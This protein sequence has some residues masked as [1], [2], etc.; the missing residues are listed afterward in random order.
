[1]TIRGLLLANLRYHWRSHLGVLIG[2]TLASAIITGAL[3]IGD[4]V[5]YSLRQMAL[6][7]LGEIHYALHNRGRFFRAELASAVASELK[8]PTASL[9]L[10]P[11]T[12]VGQRTDGT[13]SDV[14]VGRVQVLGVT[15]DFWKLGNASPPTMTSPTGI[16]SVALNDHLARALGVQVGDEVLLRVDKPSLLSRDAP[17]STIEDATVTLRLAVAAIVPE[18]GFGR[19][20]LEA[21]QVPPYNAF[22]PL[23]TL[24]RAVGME[25]RTNTLLVGGTSGANDANGAVSVSLQNALEALWKH[26]EFADSGLTLRPVPGKNLL[27]LRTNQVFLDTPLGEA[28]RTAVPDT[29]GVLTYFVNELRVGK[30]ATPYSTVAALQSPLLPPGMRD[31]E[32]VVNQWFADDVGAKV[33]D[34]VSLKYWLVGSMRRL[35]EH[36][37]SFRIR[38]ILPM[39][40]ATIDPALMPDIPGLSDKKDCRDWEPG[41]PVDLTKIRDKDQAY[42]DAYRG[43]PKGFITLAAGQRIWNNRFGDL[44]A[45]RYPVTGPDTRPKVEMCLRQSLSPASQGMFFQPVRENALNASSQSLDFGQLFLAFSFF[46]IVAA[47]LLT[48]LLF[49]FGVERRAGETGT[50]LALGFTP[51]RVQR[52]LLGEGAALAALASLLG[53]GLATLYGKAVLGGLSTVWSGAVADAS[54]RYHATPQTLVIGALSGFLMALLTIFLVTRRQ[55]TVPARVLL[56]AGSEGVLPAETKKD[57]KKKPSASTKW[58]PGVRA[59]VISFV[60][61]IGLTGAAG[62]ASGEASAGYFFGAG[63]LLLM[64]GIFAS[65]AFLYRHERAAGVEPLT[66]GTLSTRNA[67]RR[68]GRSLSAIAL[69]ACGSFL[70]VAVGANR[71][72]PNEGARERSSGT[73]GFAFYGESALP[74]YEDLNTE[75]GR[76]RFALDSEALSD[77]RIV[78]LRL[79]EGDEASCLNLNRVQTPRLLGVPVDAL[80]ER[81]AF[82]FAEIENPPGADKWRVLDAVLPDGAIPVVGDMNTVLWSLGKKLGDTLSYV[83]DRGTTHRL[84]I[85]GVLANSI[86]QGGLLLSEDNFIRLFPT[87]SGYR[88]FLVD[89]SPSAASTVAREL[90]TGLEDIG[91]TLTPT[92]ERLAAFNTVENTYLSVFAVLGG[93]GLVLGSV[94]L[95]VI[96]L[97]NVL[98]RQREFALLRAIGYPS[99]TLHS[100][101]LREHTLLLVLGLT[102][103]VIAALLAVLPALRHPGAE[104]PYGTLAITLLAVFANGF[105]WTWAST[106][107]ALHAPL[108]PALRSE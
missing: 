7:R 91:L 103:G 78:P 38:A 50:L 100:L 39:Q 35:E 27:E 40:G 92:V 95:G 106:T 63:A 20:S 96:V 99:Q 77:S 76:D 2:A 43:S 22:L 79:R 31:D 62:T 107:L 55:A 80:A 34:T 108:L 57:S 14:R 21:N 60:L 8:T 84:R 101:V 23:R 54:L 59:A 93:L 16:E 9:I 12:A 13:Q 56:G 68:I 67:A 36:T 29:Q 86:L 75:D 5:R 11:G 70:V 66:L 17:L 58:L 89:A 42:W 48:A 81:K 61:A 15:D 18:S 10:L 88:T 51:R 85:V 44:T 53:V 6:S 19:F 24:Q 82:T 49:A 3:M 71:H 25:D 41:V 52:L 104:I 65:R 72:D 30:Q 94:G 32:I 97:R 90:T 83:D 45:V 46:L 28:A 4:S 37:S 47:L 74:V 98:E 73:G 1:M 64:A 26:W 102:I 87:E 33:G 105:L 69:L